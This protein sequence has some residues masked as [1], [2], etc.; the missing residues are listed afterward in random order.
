MKTVILCGGS[1]TRLWPIS[2][3][4]SPKQFAQI[5][6][7][8]SLFEKTITRNLG[9]SN[10]LMV[11]VNDKQLPLCKKQVPQNILANTDFLIE[12]CA[13]NTAPA[14]ALAALAS[15]PDEVLLILPSDHLIKDLDV[16]ENCVTEAIKLA[17]NDKLVT[18]GIKP[19]YPETGF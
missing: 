13:R 18:F 9:L 14:I 15:D 6:N 5:F 7:G 16:Y 1:G 3:E 11:V 4:S 8:E 10:E 17:Q 12:S 19:Q 2:R